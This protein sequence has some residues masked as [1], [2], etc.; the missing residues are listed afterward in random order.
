MNAR[1]KVNG[2]R[3]TLA[4]PLAPGDT[5]LSLS[6]ALTDLLGAVVSL[7]SGDVLPLSLLDTNGELVEVLH[8]TDY[9]GATT[10]TV[11]RGQEGTTAVAASAGQVLVN[12]PTA[13]DFAGSGGGSYRGE[14]FEP[15]SYVIDLTLGL[16]PGSTSKAADVVGSGAVDSNVVTPA[17]PEVGT[18]GGVPALIYGGLGPAAVGNSRY[19]A[20][21]IPLPDYLGSDV[22]P[23]TFTVGASTES[24][25]YDFAEM[26]LDREIAGA[27]SDYAADRIGDR[28]GGNVPLTTYSTGARAIAA[29]DH[30]VWFAYRK[31]GSGTGGEDKVA[32]TNISYPKVPGDP[33]DYALGD[34]V[35]YSGTLYVCVDPTQDTPATSMAP[36]RP[37]Y[38]APAGGGEAPGPW[39]NIELINGWTSPGGYSI[40][41]YRKVSPTRVELRGYLSGGNSG[42]NIGVLP[43][44]FRPAGAETYP[45]WMFDDNSS[46][47]FGGR[48]DINPEGTI[49]PRAFTSSQITS[50]RTGLSHVFFDPT[51]GS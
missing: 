30:F 41:Q 51:G 45:L 43:S 2:L 4:S 47:Y 12:A 10:A 35:L 48:L 28:I 39:T 34:T 32:L 22:G 18:F 8:V 33:V 44:G 20:V 3:A 46:S 5:S 25:N 37:A 31:D 23:I 36:W 6:T 13:L 38:T 17:D 14:V 26:F 9:P 19:K 40:A 49:Q 50:T 1:L 29:G 15:G 24:I 21:R 42:Q 7:P 11:L 27:Y 16:P